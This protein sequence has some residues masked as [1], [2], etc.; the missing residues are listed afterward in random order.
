MAARMSP[1]PGAAAGAEERPAEAARAVPVAPAA[2]PR[3]VA[4]HEPDVR[5]ARSRRQRPRSETV[6][7]VIVFFSFLSIVFHHDIS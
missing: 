3:P 1:R 2:A 6:I 7:A 4:G 5:G